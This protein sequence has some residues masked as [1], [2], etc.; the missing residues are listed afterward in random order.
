MS[1]SLGWK[2][3]RLRRMGV[4]EITFRAS[5]HISQIAEKW[6]VVNGWAPQPPAPVTPRRSLLPDLDEYQPQWAERYALN[7]AVLDDLIAG[8]LELFGH[9]QIRLVQ[10]VDWHLDPV[11]GVRA[12]VDYGKSLDYRNAALVGNVKVIWELGRQHHL[13]PLAVAYAVGGDKRYLRVVTEQIESWIQQNPFAMGIHWCS[14]LELALRLISWSLIHSLI[15]S[16]IGDQGLFSVVQDPKALG[17]AIFQQAW[18]VRH[19]L[20]R[21]SSAN[22]HLFGELSGLWVASQ[23]FDMGADGDRWRRET[24]EE[25]EAQLQLQVYADGVDKEQ[26]LYYHL[27]MLEYALF[28]QVTGRRVGSPLFRRIL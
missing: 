25:L 11:S 1:G 28:V 3:Q 17:D 16:R 20:S 10:P 14:A 4:R 9:H 24:Q 19:Y 15:A 23:V 18:F 12:P 22:N 21:Y 7:H 2:L 13:V 5:R 8:S 27:W 6:R 26:A